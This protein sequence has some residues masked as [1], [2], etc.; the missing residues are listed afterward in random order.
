MD[1]ARNLQ[2]DIGA[3]AKREQDWRM[4]FHSVKCNIT[5]V[6]QKQNQIQ[7][8]DKL[9]GHSAFSTK[10]DSTKYLGAILQSNLKWDK[11]INNITSKAN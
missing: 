5:S 10:T 8:T 4:C 1:E 11:H 3:A 9:H 7:F 6:T 2:Q